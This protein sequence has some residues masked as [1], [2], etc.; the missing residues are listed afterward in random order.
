MHATFRY[1][2]NLSEASLAALMELYAGFDGGN[3]RPADCNNNRAAFNGIQWVS[4]DVWVVDFVGDDT[5]K[6]YGME[7][8]I[9]YFF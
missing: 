4:T 7:C 8:E 6:G 5:R 9:L 3:N 2:L 1:V